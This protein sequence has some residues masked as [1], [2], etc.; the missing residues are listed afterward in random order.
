MTKEEFYRLN[1]LFKVDM[2]AFNLTIA[3][4]TSAELDCYLQTQKTDRIFEYFQLD[5]PR[6]L[7]QAMWARE[8][9]LRDK[10]TN[11]QGSGSNSNQFQF[12]ANFDLNQTMT[13]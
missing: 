9:K 11:L 1:R 8:S 10:L 13:Q 12:P 5:R 2:K 4:M 3:Q 6:L 7:I